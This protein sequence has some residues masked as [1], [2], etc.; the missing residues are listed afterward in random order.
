MIGEKQKHGNQAGNISMENTDDISVIEYIYQQNVSNLIKKN[1]HKN[2]ELV[3]EVKN[4]IKRKEE[5]LKKI[6]SKG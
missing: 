3:T 1:K 5:R 6:C 2:S 4:I